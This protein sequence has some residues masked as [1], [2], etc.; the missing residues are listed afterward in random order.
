MENG[1]T[2]FDSMHVCKNKK[3]IPVEIR[4]RIYVWQGR[5]VILSI[6]RDIT[7]RRLAE[8]ALRESEEFRSSLLENSPTSVLVINPDTS[9]KYINPALESLTGYTSAEL[10]G[11]KAPYPWWFAPDASEA[12]S[13]LK[14][15]ISEGG[16]HLERLMQKKN[17]EG[18][19]VEINTSPIRENGELK[20]SLSTWIDITERRLSEQA[21][22][23]SEEFRSS[24]L[25]N[26]PTP[27]MVINQDTSIM[28]VN[29]ALEALTG[30]SSAELVGSKAPHAFWADNE[31]SGKV[32]EMKADIP[33]GV[34]GLVKVFRKKNGE[35][36]WVEITSMPIARNGAFNYTLANWVDITERK[37]VEEERLK[38]DSMKSEFI[39]NVSHEL[40]T[41]LHT[42]KGF[43]KLLLAGEVPES[44]TQQEFM[45]IID[46]QSEQLGMLIESL[47]DISRLETGRFTIQKQPV[48]L[49]EIIIEAVK[50]FSGLAVEKNIKIIQ[51]IPAALPQVEADGERLRQVMSNLLGNAIKFSDAGTSITARCEVRGGEMLV[52]VIDQGAGISEQAL[53]HIFE[54][55]YRAEET[56]DKG[57]TGLGLYIVKQIIESHGGN[58]WAESRAGG[59]SI[60]SF[61]LPLANSGGDS[62]G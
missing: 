31:E 59:G 16:R 22:R 14:K 29:P 42:I 21:L 15:N 62:H 4:A 51:D 37:R 41:P 24:L 53:P 36:F 55:F 9:I 6:A 7:E 30:F 39:S 32:G 23:E 11:K 3:L 13:F 50:T 19:W 5:D 47:L 52:R 61:T 27:M 49:G 25:E 26:A 57:G 56:K 46:K 10:V 48:L 38:L 60:F 34:R 33:G 40:R 43:T 12:I 17:G 58:I 28:Y 35:R 2:C 44:E 20:Y 45:D 8:E 1:E 54:R 18:F